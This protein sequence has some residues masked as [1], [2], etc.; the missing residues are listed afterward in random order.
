MTAAAVRSIMVGVRL[1]SYA[2]GQQKTSSISPRTSIAVQPCSYKLI[3]WLLLSWW[4]WFTRGAYDSG[5]GGGSIDHGVG[6][7]VAPPDKNNNKKVFVCLSSFG[8]FFLLCVHRALYC[9]GTTATPLFHLRLVVVSSAHT[10]YSG[11]P[12]TRSPW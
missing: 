1:A 10:W 6:S 9:T 2:G 5:G 3:L 11:V 12:G 4:W 8:C 7:Q